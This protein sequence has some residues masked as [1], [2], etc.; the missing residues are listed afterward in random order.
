MFKRRKS[1]D[2][3]QDEDEQLDAELSVAQKKATLRELNQRTGQ[4]Q[5][6]K[7]FSDNGRQSGINFNRIVAWLKVH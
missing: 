3:L 2:E 5:S 6:W 4:T 1:L 7:L